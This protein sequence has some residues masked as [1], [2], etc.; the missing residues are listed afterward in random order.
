MTTPVERAFQQLYVETARV[1]LGFNNSTLV[2][3]H[4]V[5]TWGGP[6]IGYMGEAKVYDPFRDR[7]PERTLVLIDSGR[8]VYPEPNTTLLDHLNGETN[9]PFPD[10][11]SMLYIKDFWG[12]KPVTIEERSSNWFGQ[13]RYYADGKQIGAPQSG[14]SL[15]LPESV[16]EASEYLIEAVRER[17]QM[18]YARDVY[19]FDAEDRLADVEN[20]RVVTEIFSALVSVADYWIGQ[21]REIDVQAERVGARGSSYF[22]FFIEGLNQQDHNEIWGLIAKAAGEEIDKRRAAEWEELFS[23]IVDFQKVVSLFRQFIGKYGI[24]DDWR[25]D[26][27]KNIAKGNRFLNSPKKISATAMPYGRTA[28]IVLALNSPYGRL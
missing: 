13:N 26:F 16:K 14:W 23:N 12:E 6:T 1:R 19:V 28:K 21:G 11:P 22:S 10:P 27:L 17:R 24:K 4:G 20:L 7:D 5:G 18:D 9:F 8:L 15:M 2:P 3:I 25:R